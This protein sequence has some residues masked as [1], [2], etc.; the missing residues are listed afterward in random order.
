VIAASVQADLRPAAGRMAGR[1]AMV[2][3]GASGI[4]LATA[5]RLRAE[6]ADVVVVDRSPVPDGAALAPDERG[7]PIAGV[8]TDVTDPRQVAA[9]VR[10][11]ADR[12]GAPADVLVNA[13]GIYRIRPLLEL[14]A[15]EWDETLT[16]NLRGP[17]LV[18][19][20]FAVALIEAGTPGA[21]VNIGSTAAV[22]ADAAEP[23]AHYNASKAGVLALTRQMA[24][25][26]APHGIRANAVCPGVIDTPMLRLMDNPASGQA[27]LETGVPLRR[28]GTAVEIAAVIVFLASHDASYLTGTAIMADGGSTAI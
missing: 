10:Q 17:F 23:S 22:V 27:Y 4:G 6:G 28:L 2:T 7:T 19:Q 25:E 16:V 15:P 20:A 11:A 13:A 18:G 8:E 21:I 3:G 9:A 14:S 26:W 1:R 24:V 12:L 5:L